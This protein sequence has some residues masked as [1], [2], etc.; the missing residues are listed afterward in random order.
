MGSLRFMSTIEDLLGRNSRVYRTLECEPV[1]TVVHFVTC[2]C[3]LSSEALG[4]SLDS[5]TERMSLHEV[6]TKL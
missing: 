4:S 2:S 1:V 5:Q 6:T 3:E